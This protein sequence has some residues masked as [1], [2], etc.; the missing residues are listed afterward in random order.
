[1]SIGVGI[2]KHVAVER[3]VGNENIC[4]CSKARGTHPVA[5]NRYEKVVEVQ[6]VLLLGKVFCIHWNGNFRTL[7]IKVHE[8]LAQY[9]CKDFFP[10]Y[11]CNVI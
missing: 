1:M 3:L 5:A 11:I 4:Q 10:L 7:E 6:Q 2:G 8:H 9:D